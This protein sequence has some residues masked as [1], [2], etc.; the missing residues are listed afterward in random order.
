MDINLPVP[1]KYIIA[2]SGGVDSVCLLD[3]MFKA[4]KYELIVAHFDHGIRSNSSKDENFVR[5][6]A[7][8]KGLVYETGKVN[9]G[10]NASES[11]A[12]TK[13]YDFLFNIC[14]RHKALA[15]ITA[16][17]EDDRLETLFIN[18]IRGTNRLGL[19]SITEKENLK[20]PFLNVPKADIKDYAYQLNLSW[21]EDITNRNDKY[22][23]N[24]IR[25]NLMPKLHDEVRQ[26]LVDLMNRQVVIN[27]EID[28]LLYRLEPSLNSY[29]LNRYM[30][31]Y[32]PFLAAKELIAN[33]L[34]YNKLSDFNQ[35]S[36]ERLTVAVKTK[37]VGTKLDVYN[38]RQILIRKDSLALINK[39]R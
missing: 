6:M 28:D 34:R 32:L 31:N 13:R 9:L 20:R 36:I 25:L 24:Y 21:R 4:N 30:V 14:H 8:Q 22:L 37:T 5:S 7:K 26:S 3:I 11:L 16:H 35:K 17:H 12:R 38:N 27:Q 2:V 10:Q 23:R 15:V 33:W 39:E 18:L 19:G 1:G 29:Q